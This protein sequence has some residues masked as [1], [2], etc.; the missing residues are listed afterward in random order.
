MSLA[1]LYSRAL[2]GMDAPDE[3]VE[4]KESKDRV[5]AAIQTTKFEFPARRI[6]INLA[7]ADLPK[8]SGR[9]LADHKSME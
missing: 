8:E 3:V 2:C 4:L 6:T 7:P 9:P 1:V 5:C